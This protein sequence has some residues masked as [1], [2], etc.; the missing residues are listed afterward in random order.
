MEVTG[1]LLVIGDVAQFGAKKWPK[2]EIVVETDEKF[3]QKISI[4]LGGDK[5]TLTDI[6]K[7]GDNVSVSINLRGREWTDPKTGSTRYFN[8]ISAWKIDRAEGNSQ[9]VLE[10]EQGD[11]PF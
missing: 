2:R 5:T 1:K 7:V 11:L 8:T 9:P 3:P 10:E 6:Y 4:E